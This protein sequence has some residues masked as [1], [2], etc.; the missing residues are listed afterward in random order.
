MNHRD[1]A[2]LVLL[3]AACAANVWLWRGLVKEWRR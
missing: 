3:I 2:C 1:V